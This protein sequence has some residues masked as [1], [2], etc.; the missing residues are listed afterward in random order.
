M[1]STD[2]LK[3]AASRFKISETNKLEDDLTTPQIIQEYIYSRKAIRS[4][5]GFIEIENKQ[6]AER[7]KKNV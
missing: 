4:F 2:E 7:N 1:I 5:I 6:E 3:L